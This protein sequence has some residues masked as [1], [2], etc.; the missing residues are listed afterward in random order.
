MVSSGS[1]CINP[2]YCVTFE[3]RVYLCARRDPIGGA[4]VNL[5]PGSKPGDVYT[6][7]CRV[8]RSPLLFP[9]LARLCALLCLYPNSTVYGVVSSPFHRLL[10]SRGH[11]CSPLSPCLQVQK[12][13]AADLVSPPPS[14]SNQKDLKNWES[15][16]KCASFV[17]G[18]IDRFVVC[19]CVGTCVCVTCCCLFLMVH[20]VRRKVVKQTV[21]TSV[22]GVTFA[23]ARAQIKVRASVCPPVH[24]CVCVPV[25]SLYEQLIM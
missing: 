5:T 11:T 15:N 17:N 25:Y 10:F 4:A 2:L 1:V 24:T 21:M 18:N 23:G 12:R 13:I 16:R 19:M 9:P 6:D 7:V 3:D 8:V 20:S 22:Y 14:S